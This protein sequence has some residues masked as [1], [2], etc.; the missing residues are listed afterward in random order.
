MLSRFLLDLLV[1]LYSHHYT[2][3]ENDSY[4]HPG[5]LHAT[6]QF[7][8]EQQIVWGCE[9]KGFSNFF[10]L[11]PNKGGSIYVNLGIWCQFYSSKLVETKKGKICTLHWFRQQPAPVLIIAWLSICLLSCNIILLPDTFKDLWKTPIIGEIPYEACWSYRSQ[12]CH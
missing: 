4:P 3:H 9:Q 11:Q 1:I 6:L 8:L 10:F 5:K 2:A 12:G 7:N